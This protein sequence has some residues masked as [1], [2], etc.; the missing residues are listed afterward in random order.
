VHAGTVGAAG[1]DTVTVCPA[2]VTVAPRAA[3][4]FAAAAIVIVA[5]PR[6]TVGDVNVTH[7][8]LEDADQ[9]HAGLIVSAIEAGPPPTGTLIDVGLTDGA[10][11]GG[12]AGGSGDV[13]PAPAWVMVR[14]AVPIVIVVSRSGPGF[15]DASNSTAPGPRPDVVRRRIHDAD[16][17][18]VHVQPSS[19]TTSILPRPPV[20]LSRDVPRRSK[21]H[22]RASCEIVNR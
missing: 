8:S 11:L 17:A 21:V 18:A 3:P 19:V 13:S 9:S 6:P 14:C 1:C 5:L 22:G 10:Q 12:T 20:E 2:I 4:V 15:G 7:E 16:V